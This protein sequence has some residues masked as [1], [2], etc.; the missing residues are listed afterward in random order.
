MI[1]SVI[2]PRD[3]NEISLQQAIMLGVINPES[4]LYINPDTNESQ[5]IPTAMT[6]G[7]IKVSIVT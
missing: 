4:G 7:L 3:Q 6:E 2:D 1:R 5:P